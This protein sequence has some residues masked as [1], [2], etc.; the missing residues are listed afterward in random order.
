MTSLIDTSYE[1]GIQPS[2][3]VSWSFANAVSGSGFSDAITDPTQQALVAAAFVTWSAAS[4][5]NFVEDAPGSTSD[6]SIGFAQNLA[7]R[8]LGLTCLS[9]DDSG[10][11]TSGTTVHLQDPAY[12]SLYT[13]SNGLTYEAAGTDDDLNPTFEQLTLHEIGHTLGLGESS[14]AYSIMN[15]IL[16]PQNTVLD[17]TDYA[18][19][20]ALYPGNVFATT[21][22][23]AALVVIPPTLTATSL[24][25][26]FTD[27][28][29]TASSP[30]FLYGGDDA[31]SVLASGAN[32]SVTTGS[33][34][35]KIAVSSGNNA[36]NGGSGSN[37]LI[38]GTGTD[39]FSSILT[40]SNA[41]TTTEN[42]HAGDSMVLWGFMAGVSTEAWAGVFGSPELQG[43]TLSV[44]SGFG[45]TE[46]I[47]FAGVGSVANFAMAEGQT[48]AG[49]PYLIVGELG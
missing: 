4:G 17:A 21:A 46:N 42:F 7:S 41:W 10:A 11:I 45:N 43:Q 6:I 31:L 33:G 3:T 25:G 47:T 49:V 27:Y 30:Q 26:G 15:P 2:S 12:T 38:G 40:A 1:G 14:D 19:V 5:I 20:E 36:L 28:T 22:P 39:S 13:G 29:S 35:D 9:T 16:L 44:S 48:A 23:A 34:N 32:A 18:N 24:T 37:L 8:A